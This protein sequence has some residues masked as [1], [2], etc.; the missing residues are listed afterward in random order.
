MGTYL[1]GHKLVLEVW[2]IR[3][4]WKEEGHITLLEDRKMILVVSNYRHH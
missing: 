1:V 3:M 2:A 4:S